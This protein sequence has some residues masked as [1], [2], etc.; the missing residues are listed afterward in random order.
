MLHQHSTLNCKG[1][2]LDLSNPIVMG[3]L[4]VTPDSFF[5]GGKYSSDLQILK[6]AEKMINEGAKILD[7]GGMSSRPG[8]EIIDTSEE[9]QRVLP[10]IRAISK[11]FPNTIQ[12]IDTINSIVAAEAVAN[13]ASIINDISAGSLDKKMFQTVAELDVP[14]ILMHMKG[15]PNNMQENPVYDDVVVEILDF[16]IEKIGQLRNLGVKDIIIDLG[17]GFGKE[18]DDNFRL[19][20]SMHAFKILE[21][22]ILAGISRKSFIYKT[23][24]TD[25][26]G[27]LAGTIAL[28]MFALDQG[29]KI[30]RVHDVKEAVDTIKIWESLNNI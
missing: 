29:A 7:I 11:T 9:L 6:Q 15:K 3:I 25:V 23:L 18:I 13:G 30:L 28:N 20:K 4:N 5:D 21:F 27:A 24:N 17:F 26:E 22:P 19:L 10:T 14:Y 12:S 8:A 2:L 1:L 16:L